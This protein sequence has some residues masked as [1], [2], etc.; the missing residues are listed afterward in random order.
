MDV[1]ELFSDWRSITS[2]VPKGSVLRPKL[3]AIY[4]NDLDKNT[5]RLT[6]MFADYTKIGDVMDSGLSK[7]MTG[8]RLTGKVD[9]GSA[10]GILFRQ[11]QSDAFW[12]KNKGRIYSK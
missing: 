1:V 4:I 10:Y 5:G 2:D 9:K 7:I 12:N 6:S 8:S 11:L 3:L